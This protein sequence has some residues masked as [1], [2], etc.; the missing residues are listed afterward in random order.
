MP[1]VNPV[2]PHRAPWIVRAIGYGA[3]LA[4]LSLPAA[5]L[6]VRFDVG[7]IGPGLLLI[8]LACLT[9]TLLLTV[10]LV[11]LLLPRYAPQRPRLLKTCVLMLPPALLLMQTLGASGLPPIHDISTDLENPP[12]FTAALALRGSDANPLAVKTD[13]LAQQRV[14]Y[15]DIAPLT[16][17]LSPGLALERAAEIAT[18]LGWEVHRIDHEAG[19]LE[20]V[21]TTFWMGFK[22]DIVV[23]VSHQSG[24]SVVD[25]RSVSRLGVSDLGTNATRI[26]AFLQ[27]YQG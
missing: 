27:A 2:K 1:E 11:L 19:E 6:L 17:S 16:T 23:R 18:A 24:R 20:A 13:N 3:L 25:L 4:L 14:A 8:A 15:P 7:G 26:R 12:Q 22:D 21:D 5:V 9:A 10:S